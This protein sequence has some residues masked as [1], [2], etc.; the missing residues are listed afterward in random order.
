MNPV[1]APMLAAGSLSQRHGSDRERLAEAAR[2][3]AKCL[4]TKSPNA[5]DHPAPAKA[6]P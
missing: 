3:M 6:R 4:E 5:D 2:L 1:S